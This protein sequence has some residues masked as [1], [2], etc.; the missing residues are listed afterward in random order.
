MYCNYGTKDDKRIV[1]NTTYS[2][3]VGHTET[4][5]QKS[6]SCKKNRLFYLASHL[7][8][9]KHDVIYDSVRMQVSRRS[10]GCTQTTLQPMFLQSEASPYAKKRFRMSPS[11]GEMSAVTTS[12]RKWESTRTV[13]DKSN[14]N[15]KIWTGIHKSPHF[16]NANQNDVSLIYKKLGNVAFKIY[17]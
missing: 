4:T 12:K 17:Q 15:T 8:T 6:I 3:M 7:K 16:L 10:R 9:A 5:K 2:C 13:T 14:T 1:F 11:P